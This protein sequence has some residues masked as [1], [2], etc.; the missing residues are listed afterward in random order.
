MVDRGLAL[1]FVTI[2]I[3]AKESAASSALPSHPTAPKAE[4]RTETKKSSTQKS[5]PRIEI[6]IPF[7]EA[8][9]GIQSFIDPLGD[10]MDS[11]EE[12]FGPLGSMSSEDLVESI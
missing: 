11:M 1:L 2:F 9:E 3:F 12:A 8:D 4:A 5:S 7:E 6:I 10:P